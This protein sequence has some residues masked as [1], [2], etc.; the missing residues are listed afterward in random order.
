MGVKAV[1]ITDTG[2]GV[3]VATWADLDAGDTGSPVLLPPYSEVSVQRTAGAGT[4]AMQGSNDGTTYG[5]LGAGVAPDGT[6][7]RV[8]E[9]PLYIR[10]SASV[11]DDNT[12]VMI[13]SGYRNS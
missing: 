2:M 12:V 10:P 5:A 6:I 11:S 3:M 7:K 1:K 4:I 8:A 13:M 9:H